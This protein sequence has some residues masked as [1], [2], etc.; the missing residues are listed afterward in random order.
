VTE[1]MEKRVVEGVER[2]ASALER[3]VSSGRSAAGDPLD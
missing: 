2:I 1:E 3:I